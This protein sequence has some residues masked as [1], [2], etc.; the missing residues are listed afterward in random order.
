[1]KKDLKIDVN[2]MVRI[3]AT[4]TVVIIPFLVLHFIIKL[5]YNNL[6]PYIIYVI[7]FSMVY[8]AVVFISNRDFARMI[9]GKL[10]RR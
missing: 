6:F 7:L 5:D 10:H 1:M 4:S 8:F 9:I 3:A 2:A